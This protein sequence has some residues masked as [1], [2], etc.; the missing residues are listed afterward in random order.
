MKALEMTLVRYT[1]WP[2]RK[3]EL[4]VYYLGFYILFSI[5][6]QFRVNQVKEFSSPEFI[7][8]NSNFRKKS[9]KSF[10]VDI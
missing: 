1:L 7:S 5:A 9:L 2:L 8:I 6:E 4:P 10:F 3:L